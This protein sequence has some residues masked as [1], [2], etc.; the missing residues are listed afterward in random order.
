LKGEIEI[1]RSIE[2]MPMPLFNKI[3]VAE[4]PG[5]RKGGAKVEG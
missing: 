3:R 5:R 2:S 1:E 4:N